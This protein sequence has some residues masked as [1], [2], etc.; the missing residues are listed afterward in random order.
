MNITKITEKVILLFTLKKNRIGLIL[1]LT[2][3][4][5]NMDRHLFGSLFKEGQIFTFENA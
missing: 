3:V 5:Q 2:I 1:N 4:S